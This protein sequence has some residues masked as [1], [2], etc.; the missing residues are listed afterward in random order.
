M[1]YTPQFDPK[2][3]SPELRV[4]SSRR[5]TTLIGTTGTAAI[6]GTTLDGPVFIRA[7]DPGYHGNYLTVESSLSSAFTL[8]FT[9]TLEI[10]KV[11]KIK[12]S[13]GTSGELIGTVAGAQPARLISV[14]FYTVT[15]AI[16]K[17]RNTGLTATFTVAG[18][19]VVKDEKLGVLGT[20][21]V[22]GYFR[23][24]SVCFGLKNLLVTNTGTDTITFLAGYPQETYNYPAE[25]PGSI[26]HLKIQEIS[27]DVNSKSEL[28]TIIDPPG[29][30]SD[31]R[32][33]RTA[34]D[35][36]YPDFKFPE[37]NKQKLTKGD[38]P[39]PSPNGVKTG[40]TRSVIL[41]LGTENQNGSVMKI[42][43]LLEWKGNSA[44]EGSWQKSN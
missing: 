42:E 17:D 15:N 6:T 7:K 8:T 1:T 41:L 16:V 31:V 43:Q 34:A 33:T 14:G 2:I 27:Q 24:S 29:H 18:S 32:D 12:L 36:F 30:L 3:D 35:V 4:V 39:P 23:S 10:P 38:G 22:G 9:A 19:A 20:F 26:S 5:S 11:D 21:T 13:L 28:I 44:S 37:F 40:P 25:S